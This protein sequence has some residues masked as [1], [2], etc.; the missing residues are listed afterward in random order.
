MNLSVALRLGRVSN[1]PTVWTNVFTGV[2][3]AGAAAADARLAILLVSLSLFYIGGMFLNDAFDSAFDARSRPERPI[4]LGQVSAAQVYVGG[5]GML[6]VNKI[7]AA[8][9]QNGRK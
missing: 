4:P 3:L 2:A 1:V 7:P 9:G 6:A 5:F 8:P